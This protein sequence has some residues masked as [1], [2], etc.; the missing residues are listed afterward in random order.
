MLIQNQ[1]V[2]SCVRHAD[3]VVLAR[4]RREVNHKEQ[5]FLPALIPAKERENRTVRIVRIDPLKA[6]PVVVQTVQRRMRAVKLQ[7]S[8][9]KVLHIPVR[10]LV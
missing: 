4:N 2:T 9:H 10:R 6:L 7:E 8:P 1:P 3:T 5:R